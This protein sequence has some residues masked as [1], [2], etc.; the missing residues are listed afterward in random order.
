MNEQKVLKQFAENMKMEFA[1]KELSV[2]K[3]GEK[4]FGRS[5]D[6]AAVEKYL[7]LPCTT[8]YKDTGCKLVTRF[9][10]SS[11]LYIM[12]LSS[13][14]PDTFDGLEAEYVIS[15]IKKLIGKIGE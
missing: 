8:V 5:L 10:I 4:L 12:V 7:S 1:V 2:Y 11:D 15:D 9:N 14:K 6:S 3:N 13:D